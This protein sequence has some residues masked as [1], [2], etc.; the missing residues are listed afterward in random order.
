MSEPQ[1][2]TQ[3]APFTTMLTQDVSTAP[4]PGYPSMPPMPRMPR[5]AGP[6][7][8]GMAHSPQPVQ[9]YQALRTLNDYM[10]YLDPDPG[11]G[12]RDTWC[13]M[14]RSLVMAGRREAYLADAQIRETWH[15]DAVANMPTW[16]LGEDFVPQL[17]SPMA[18]VRWFAIQAGLGEDSLIQLAHTEFSEGDSVDTRFSGRPEQMW[19]TT[20]F[21]DNTVVN[22][23]SHT[24]AEARQTHTG[25]VGRLISHS[26]DE[27]VRETRKLEAVAT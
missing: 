1:T 7:M 18:A 23:P 16:I 21:A 11:P 5:G 3:N 4:F 17:V 13:G 15:T 8:P 26:G 25:C 10:H 12:Y 6:G 14:A 20:V 2:E 9:S 22:Y 27:P 24:L 19:V